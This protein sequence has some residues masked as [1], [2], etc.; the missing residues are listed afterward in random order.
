M[1]KCN[2]HAPAPQNT[3]EAIERSKEGSCSE[4]PTSKNQTQDVHEHAED[5]SE[6]KILVNE[7][8]AEGSTTARDA[9]SDLIAPSQEET[10][11][12]GGS[13]EVGKTEKMQ[14]VRL[15][16]AV[17][18]PTEMLMTLTALYVLF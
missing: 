13:Q 10:S 7:D 12:V 8:K 9:P 16:V 1:A 5:A 4:A 18:L 11:K 6:V 15:A 3:T 2:D 14:E 17:M